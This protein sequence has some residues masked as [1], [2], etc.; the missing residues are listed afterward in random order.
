MS[1]ANGEL[2]PHESWGFLLA[3]FVRFPLVQVEPGQLLEQ[4]APVP[5]AFSSGPDQLHRHPRRQGDADSLPVELPAPHAID[6]LPTT[7]ACARESDQNRTTWGE[8]CTRYL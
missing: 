1:D 4:P 6:E 8:L 3:L 7:P 5:T 2:E